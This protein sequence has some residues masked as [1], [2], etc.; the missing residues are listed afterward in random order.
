[1]R[2]V[3]V[4]CG[5]ETV[6][7]RQLNYHKVALVQGCVCVCVHVHMRDACMQSASVCVCVC[8]CTCVCDKMD[9]DMES[10]HTKRDNQIMIK[11]KQMVT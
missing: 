1:M 9:P 10:H 8:A 2:G 6:I 7:G 4:D 3:N 11:T 5:F